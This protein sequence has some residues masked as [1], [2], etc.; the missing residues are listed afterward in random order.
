[1]TLNSMGYR[2]FSVRMKPI[3]RF[4][5]GRRDFSIAGGCMLDVGGSA[6]VDILQ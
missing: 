6:Q 1:M 5:W 3:A 2:Q 4:H